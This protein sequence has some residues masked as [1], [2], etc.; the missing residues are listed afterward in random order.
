MIRAVVDS[1]VLA[2][3]FIGNPDARPS[4][5]VTARS[6]HHFVLIACPE[7]LA[8]LRDVL[9]RPKFARWSA[10]GR[11]V[12]YVAAFAAASDRH[13]D[14]T[15]ATASVRGP[16]DDYLVA[17]A[18]EADVDALVSLDRDLL[19]AG[20]T[21]IAIERPAAFLGRLPEPSSEQ[22]PR[23]QMAVYVKPNGLL[24]TGYMAAIRPFPHLILYPPMT[25]QIGRDCAGA[26]AG[27]PAGR[28]L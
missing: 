24:G 22:T 27:E 1:S 11:A 7:L 26:D 16:A 23:G 4:R 19:D 13:P 20:L 3:A 5:L 6:E 14:P 9:A 25:R 15:E 17:F 10:D 2:S 21:D 8:E 28:A 18:R 12:A